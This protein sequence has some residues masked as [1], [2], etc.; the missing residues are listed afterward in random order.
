MVLPDIND[1]FSITIPFYYQCKYFI[2]KQQNWLKNN[3]I[4][5]TLKYCNVN[6]KQEFPNHCP[7]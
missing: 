2:A 4:F 7:C 1:K 3:S 6:R 5:S